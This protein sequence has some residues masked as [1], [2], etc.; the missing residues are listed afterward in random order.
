MF[1]GI[2]LGW[3]GHVLHVLPL[4]DYCEYKLTEYISLL[5]CAGSM[6]SLG[7]VIPNIYLFIYLLNVIDVKYLKTIS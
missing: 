2:A 6:S 1:F 3:N 5:L 4:C 7:S